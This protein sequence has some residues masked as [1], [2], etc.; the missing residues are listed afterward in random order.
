VLKRY[1]YAAV[2]LSSAG[3]RAQTQMPGMDMSGTGMADM[4]PSGMHLMNLASG[5][6]QN[7]LSWP[8]PMSMLHSRGWNLMFMANAF[9]VDT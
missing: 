6:S 1:L 8:M 2:L 7:P 4:N 5:S 3:L 9:L